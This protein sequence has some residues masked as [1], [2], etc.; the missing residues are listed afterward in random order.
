M[1]NFLGEVLRGQSY[2][3]G[4]SHKKLLWRPIAPPDLTRVD[5][6]LRFQSV[7]STIALPAANK[8]ATAAAMAR[9][10]STALMVDA[11]AGAA[12]RCAA[13]GLDAEA[14]A[15]VRGAAAGADAL[16]AAAGRESVVGV[17]A[18][19][20]EAGGPPGGSVGNLMVGA[21]EGFGGRLIRTVSFLGC[22]LPVSFFGGAAPI[23][24]F[25]MFSAIN[26]ISCETRFE[27]CGCQ[28]LI[29]GFI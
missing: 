11:A 4:V 18:A 29:L 12:G 26:L 24:K 23:G 10:L 16:G 1:K 20:V 14:G 25:G 27:S 13:A 6:V 21:A 19:A 22:T 7:Q 15:P 3:V 2:H 8:L 17:E 28:T 9:I 5:Q